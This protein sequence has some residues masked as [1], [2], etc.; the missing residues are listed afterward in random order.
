[1]T[2]E[3]QVAALVTATTDLT[4]VVNAELNK[5]RTENANFKT[6]VVEKTASPVTNNTLVVFNGTSGKNIKSNPNV[7][8]NDDGCAFV[9]GIFIG[10]G[11]GGRNTT[12]LVVGRNTSLAS[13]TTG[14]NNCVFGIQALLSNTSGVNN[15]AIGFNALYA[16]TTG[17][18][19][20]ALGGD[21][22][23]LNVSGVNNTAVGYRALIVSSANNL[24]N[25]SGL[26]N[27][28]EVTGN[29]QI[30]L[31]DS[32]TTTYVF[33]TVQSRSDRRDKTDIR[34]TVLG[35]EFIK[36]LRPVDFRWDLRDS[37]RTAPPNSLL[38]TASEEEKLAY[39]EAF[40][41]YQEDNRLANIAKDGS[42]KRT[43]YHH[44]VI[45]QDIEEFIRTTGT[46][47]G[48]FQDHKRAGGDDVLSI[49]YD[50]FI[51]PLIKAVQ[52]LSQANEELTARIATLEKKVV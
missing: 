9:D 2:L 1:M 27:R 30:Q 49:G 20:V 29:N 38:D 16:N 15:T 37:Y 24:I 28:V 3:T 26:G 48:G 33:N 17:S 22:L 18:T 39:A 51:A 43:R 12:N 19:N 52:E 42:K 45:A 50:E 10:T 47:F 23:Q 8:V 31:G 14:A 46:D 11:T 25:C 35:L 41:K 21:A 44:G 6:T 5:V 40:K 32:A 4:A 7:L 36:F 13:N 34:P